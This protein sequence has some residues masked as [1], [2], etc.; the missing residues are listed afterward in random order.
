[1][2]RVI[3]TTGGTGGHIFPA[4]AVAEEI[5]RRF[6]ESRLL[7]VGGGYGPEKNIVPKAGLEFFALPARGVMGR[8]V[9][10]LGAP[11]WMSRSICRAIMLIMRFKPQAV[12]GFGG[13]AAF[14]GVLA[15]I[16][17]RVPVAIHEQNSIPG[18][19]NRL[20]GAWVRKIFLSFPDEAHI[21]PA[22][23]TVITGNPVRQAIR[24]AAESADRK[25]F[26]APRLLVAGGSLGASAINAA[27]VKA[28]PELVAAGVELRHQTGPADFEKI[29]LAYKELGV[30]SSGV[31]V[32]IEDM[33]GA[34]AWADLALCRAGATTVAELTVSGSASL[35]I[36]FPYAAG[37]HQTANARMLAQ[38]G[39]AVLLAEEDIDKEQSFAQMILNL[40]RDKAGL[41]KMRKASKEMG[42]PGAAAAVV[43]GLESMIRG[44]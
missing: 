33:A 12:I 28:L 18:M 21:F 19:A 1:M 44:N 22:G 30:D 37:D 35:L 2:Q 3:L 4:L 29:K 25:G 16:L 11:L 39:A 40:L 15:A 31:S 7:F 38:N 42:R 43:D 8:G 5:K 14:S 20:L 26:G 10:S 32:F 23:R 9:R 17:G 27:V 41:K 13:Y 24:S 34:Y 36:P 6:P